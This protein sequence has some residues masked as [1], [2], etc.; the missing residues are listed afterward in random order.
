MAII[1][2]I[3]PADSHLNI[4]KCIRL[5]LV[6][7]MAESLVGDITPLHNISKTEKHYRE[8]MALRASVSLLPEELSAQAA[9]IIALFDE[10]EKAETAEAILVKD[11]DKYELMLQTY[12]YERQNEHLGSL[13]DFIIPIKLIQNPTIKGW[14]EELLS[15]REAYWKRR[16]GIIHIEENGIEDKVGTAGHNFNYV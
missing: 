16:A 2:M 11:I 14:A 9:E 5:A 1:A 3:C 6:H 4:N 15:E 8:T 13:K 10:Y 12:E 7:D